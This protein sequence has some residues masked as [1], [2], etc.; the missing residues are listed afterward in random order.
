MTDP[1]PRKKVKKD[2]P[3][4]KKQARALK[5]VMAIKA[6]MFVVESLSGYFAHSTSLI[7]DSFDM[8]QDSIGAATSVLVRNH[9]QRWQ[10]GV[11]LAK[12]G[13]MAAGGLGVLAGAAFIFFNPVSLPVTAI[14]GIVAGAAL[15]TNAA[16]AALIYHYRK[17]NINMKSTWKCVRNDMFSNLGVLGVAG[18][19]LFMTTPIPDL[20]VGAIISALCIKSA[21]DIARDSIKILRAPENAKKKPD[22]AAPSRKAGPKMTPGFKKVLRAVFNRKASTP[23]VVTAPAQQHVVNKADNKPPTL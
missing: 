19:G 13:V 15:V 17:D 7:A 3:L 12:A 11:A 20:A 6:V 9:S 23:A 2:T 14:M 16:C 21:I 22:A 1:H 18:I 8:L 5:A 10:A 4:G